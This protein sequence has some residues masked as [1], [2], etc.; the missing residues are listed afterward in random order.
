MRAWRDVHARD[1]ARA[2]WPA[3]GAGRAGGLRMNRRQFIASVS[4][5]GLG[6]VTLAS[7]PAPLRAAG[8][9]EPPDGSIVRND[10]PEHWESEVGPLGRDW[11]TRTDLFFVRSHFPPPDLDVATWRLELEG[12]VSRGKSL[13][14]A[15]LLGMPQ[16]ERVH[17]LE[18]AGNGR[19]LMKLASTSG[20]Q[21]RYGAVG[22]ARWT[23]VLLAHVL[24][25]AGVSREAKHVWFE[26]A[27]QA[28]LPG[29]PRF[30]RS[31]SIEKAMNDVILALAMNGRPLEK[32]HG[33]PLRVVVPGWFG[34]ASTKWLTKIRVEEVAS[35]NHFMVRGYRYNAP[36]QPPEQ[37]APVE[38]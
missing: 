5:A 36:G 17:T 24:E 29:V 23:G 31:I 20:T 19:G 13:T 26:A 9:P 21:W 4:R 38:E 22:N 12:L 34:M 32:L 16:F 1:N 18:C 3:F 27:D 14:I 6:A 35:D 25:R 8:A 33:A 10:R 30:A 2:P 7:L 37:A 15:D 28:P 11:I